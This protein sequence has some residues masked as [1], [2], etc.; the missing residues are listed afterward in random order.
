MKMSETLEAPCTF[1]NIDKMQDFLR[2]RVKKGDR[3]AKFIG[4]LPHVVCWSLWS[5]KI[6]GYTSKTFGR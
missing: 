3:N 2:C 5:S 4:I 1:T 6:K